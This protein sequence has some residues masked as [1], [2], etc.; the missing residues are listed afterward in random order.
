MSTLEAKCL[1]AEL[2]SPNIGKEINPL[3]L[4]LHSANIYEV[5]IVG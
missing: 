2:S 1:R 5:S 3:G 4:T